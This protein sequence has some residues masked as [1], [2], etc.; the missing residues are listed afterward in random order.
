M[1]K[2]FQTRCDENQTGRNRRSFTYDDKIIIWKQWKVPSKRQ[3]GLQKLGINK[4]LA[5]VTA[6]V[7]VPVCRIENMR[8][9]G[10]LEED[11]NEMG[12]DLLCRLL[13][14]EKPLRDII[15]KLN[16][17][18]PTGMLCGVRGGL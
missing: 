5:R 10:P 14:G 15:L 13:Y 12:T 11:S 3:W 8:K 2:L 4:D 18:V 16:R 17:V 1:D 9:Q 7:G 6:Y